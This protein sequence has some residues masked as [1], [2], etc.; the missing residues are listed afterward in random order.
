[1]DPVNQ[2]PGST[3]LTYHVIQHPVVFTDDWPGQSMS[4]KPPL[5]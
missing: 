5:V 3:P 2:T 4:S 1:M